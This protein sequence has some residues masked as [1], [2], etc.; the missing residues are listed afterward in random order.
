ML[1]IAVISIVFSVNANIIKEYSDYKW[2]NPIDI[3][4]FV[5]QQI[6]ISQEP[7]I[8]ELEIIES[9]SSASDY[10]YLFLVDRTGSTTMSSDLKAYTQKFRDTIFNSITE[11]YTPEKKE[12]EKLKKLSLQELMCLKMNL[13]LLNKKNEGQ[14]IDIGVVFYDGEQTK[15]FRDKESYDV[16]GALYSST[17]IRDYLERFHIDEK[18]SSADLHSQRVRQFTD[19]R[20]IK[21]PR[22]NVKGRRVGDRTNFREV[23]KEIKKRYIGKNKKKNI[24][25]TVFSDFHHDEKDTQEEYKNVALQQV[26]SSIEALALENEIFQINLVRLPKI[27]STLKE[28]NEVSELLKKIKQNFS[29]TFYYHI[30]APKLIQEADIN[31]RI[32]EIASPTIKDDSTQLIFYYPYTNHKLGNVKETR[33]RFT[34]QCP[35]NK[36]AHKFYISLHSTENI[37]EMANTNLVFYFNDREY[38]DEDNSKVLKIGEHLDEAYDKNDVI[39]ASFFNVNNVQQYSDLSLN[40]FPF[41]ASS[42]IRY[43]IIFKER[44]SILNAEILGACCL[45]IIFSSIVFFLIVVFDPFLRGSNSFKQKLSI[46]LFHLGL[47]VLFMLI[48]CLLKAPPLGL[49]MLM[50][51]ILSAALPISIFYVQG[52][53]NLTEMSD[54]EDSNDTD[55]S[56]D[57]KLNKF[58]QLIN[59]AQNK[60]KLEMTTVNKIHESSEKISNNSS[61]FDE[62]LA[63]LQKQ[64]EALEKANT[65]PNH[66]NNNKARS[67][68]NNRGRNKN[69]RSGHT[70]GREKKTGNE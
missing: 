69:S 26:E 39:R 41:G 12:S 52:F 14:I 34:L 61:S 36:S 19:S 16:L 49:D 66:N 44:L 6:K 54:G 46:C 32:Q 24:I 53:L 5:D 51:P 29:N 55:S 50:I 11:T 7:E 60:L 47:A 59:D 22:R 9:D 64:I 42:K 31:E 63:A 30:D 25:L 33:T 10:T 67:K 28:E 23:F 40:I 62:K 1:A 17:G 27:E 18:K 13:S 20:I 8:N 2:Y 48:F 65:R 45:S 56:I 70:N 38:S 3:L 4:S 35:K 15:E 57:K 68:Q 21:L 37:N 43:S 58:I